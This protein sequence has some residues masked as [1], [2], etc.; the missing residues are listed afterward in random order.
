MIG[1]TKPI[2][3]VKY[4]ST[5]DNNGDATETVEVIYKL[6]AEVTDEGG[7]RSQTDGRTESSDTKVFRINFRNYNINSNYNIIYF[8]QVYGISNVKRINEKR[9]TWELTGF[10]LYQVTGDAAPPSPAQVN[11]WNSVAYNEALGG[12]TFSGGSVD[13]NRTLLQILTYPYNGTTYS[14]AYSESFSV[15]PFLGNIPNP[16]EFWT[17]FTPG[18]ALLRWYRVTEGPPFTPLTVAAEQV[19]TITRLSRRQ[20]S[21]Y[22]NANN[23]IRPQNEFPF[24]AYDVANVDLG[25]VNN[26]SEY[27]T[28]MNASAN[29]Q[30]CFNIVEDKSS[31]AGMSFAVDPIAPYQ[32]WNFGPPLKF[33]SSNI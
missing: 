32:S 22:N 9:F 17:Q 27:I 7:S 24:R 25:I 26:A 3:L 18:Q 11:N 20:I 33:N 30:V 19:I 8:G 6:W 13:N 10:S 21:V 5:I 1:N 29:N 28:V 4:T 31:T 15:G 14:N 23:L 12:L 16:D 2:K